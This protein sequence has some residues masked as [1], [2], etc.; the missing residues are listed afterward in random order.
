MSISD[1]RK[2]ITGLE[3]KLK[4]AEKNCKH[5]YTICSELIGL[6]DF[7]FC[8]EC[9]L[10]RG[11]SEQDTSD[12][13]ENKAASLNIKRQYNRFQIQFLALEAKLTTSQAETAGLRAALE[14]YK[15]AVGKIARLPNYC[16]SV[17][18]DKCDG[19]RLSKIAATA[20]KQALATPEKK[21]DK[22]VCSRCG[23]KLVLIIGHAIEEFWVRCDGCRRC[24][25]IHKTKE[26]AA[27]AAKILAKP[28]SKCGTCSDKRY[29]KNQKGGVPMCACPDCANKEN[30]E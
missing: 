12:W 18:L 27:D 15:T 13:V 20:I 5:E 6:T 7:E 26:D 29:I 1:M 2:Q 25:A 10:S 14:I 19:N 23:G 9:G 21:A 16:G 3:Q 22:N 24:T 30:A 28:K 11:V 17:P 8:L 4:D